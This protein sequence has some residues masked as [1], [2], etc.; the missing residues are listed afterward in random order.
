MRINR[1][2]RAL[3]EP[4]NERIAVKK[5]EG[6]TEFEKESI[7]CLGWVQT[8]LGVGLGLYIG[9]LIWGVAK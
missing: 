8:I 3:D 4:I 1:R 5:R 9:Y 7:R 2:L 6:F